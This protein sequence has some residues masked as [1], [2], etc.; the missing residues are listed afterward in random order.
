M[1]GMMSGI[2]GVVM[3]LMM[4]LMLVAVA[5]GAVAW[6]L[7]RLRRRS[8]DPPPDTTPR[9]IPEEIVRRRD[10]VGEIDPDEELRRRH[11]LGEH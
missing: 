3:W 4:G 6:M 10:P 2:A 7:R 1:N 11:D 9:E 5:S 8:L